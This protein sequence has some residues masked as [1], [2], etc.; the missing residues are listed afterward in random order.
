MGIG[1]PSGGSCGI[2]SRF[3]KPSSNPYL[4]N[5]AIIAHVDHGKTT[6][7]DALLAGSGVVS[8]LNHL[9]DCIL[10]SNPLERERGITI[11]SKNCAVNYVAKRGRF[12]GKLFRI[13]IIDTP[14]HADFGGEVERV[15]RMADGCLLVVDAFEGPMPQTR[16]VLTKALELGLRPIVV[17]NKCDR[18]EARPNEVVS[19][20]FDLLVDL[21]ADD[22]A[23]DFPI[24]YASGRSGW[25]T[26]SLDI[27]LTNSLARKGDVLAS[28]GTQRPSPSGE[29]YPQDSHEGDVARLDM[30][31]L[32]ETIIERVPPPQGDPN[33]TLQMLITTL[34][35]SDYVG[36]IAIGRVYNGTLL[37]DQAV[38]V[39]RADG[40]VTPTRVQKLLRFEGLTRLPVQ[41]IEVG[42]LCAIE[43]LKEFDIGDTVSSV[44][45]PRPMD[46]VHVDEPTLHMIFR[47]NDSP[48]VGK[49]GKYV[50]S[51]QIAERLE[52]E[53]Q[54][55]V[56]LRVSPG[57]SAEEFHVSGRGLLHLGVLLENMRREG[58]ELSVGKPEVIEKEIMGER[59]EPFERLTLD[60]AT[61]AMGPAMELLGSRGAEVKSMHHRGERMHI[62]CEIP[63]RGLI[64]LRSRMLTATGGEAVMYHSYSHYGPLRSVERKRTNGVMIANENGTATTYALL[65]L[66]ERGVMFVRPGDPIY[67]G[68]VVGEHSRDNDLVV[69]VVK[70]KHLSNVRASSKEQTV[71]LKAPRLLTLEAALE[72]IEQD[73]LVE[74]TPESVRIRKKLLS[75]NDRKRADRS[76]RDRA[77]A[78]A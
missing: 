70:A 74:L 27:V 7:V 5:V 64:G 69:N 42:D 33:A 41:K 60:I 49:E 24:V 52:K 67:A 15:L 32:F 37:N 75:E 62:E 36:R 57:D 18:E 61:S 2:S 38:G 20:V 31:E 25:A 19:E 58:Y 26:H 23:L 73:E 45:D 29:G 53:L 35:Y 43:G 51:R 4:R 71:V 50:T 66:V 30:T 48:F 44:E 46:R 11:F 54:S 14:G 47:I 40:S 17:V 21:N 22:H 1:R 12:A 77:E 63:A 55:N 76:A 39:C 16:F 68:Q 8:A 34:D 3:M 65:N 28:V 59:C 10:D 9:G 13:N 72:Y 6:L 56:A 78:I